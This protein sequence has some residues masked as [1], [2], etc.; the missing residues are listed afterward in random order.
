MAKQ[1][2]PEEGCTIELPEDPSGHNPFVPEKPKL[3]WSYNKL[4]KRWR[5]ERDNVTVDIYKMSSGEY[6]LI[7]DV[8]GN[9]YY[10]D[11][12]WDYRLLESAKQAAWLRYFG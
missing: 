6:R 4:R 5:C 7:W 1:R 12:D 11:Y 9:A 8:Q 3:T 2:W 10:Q